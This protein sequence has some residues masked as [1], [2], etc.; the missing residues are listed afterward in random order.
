MLLTIR[1]LHLADSG[2]RGTLDPKAILRF[3]DGGSFVMNEAP[4]AS[5]ARYGTRGRNGSLKSSAIRRSTVRSL[6]F[7]ATRPIAD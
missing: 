3:E 1:G 7:G 4:T 2:S 6:W 5:G